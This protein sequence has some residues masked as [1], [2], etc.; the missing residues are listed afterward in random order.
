MGG[1]EA[2]R[3]GMEV[4]RPRGEHPTYQGASLGYN[5]ISVATNGINLHNSDA[6]SLAQAF[7]YKFTGSIFFTIK[8]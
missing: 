7:N 2:G 5:G 6:V 1:G 8:L 3:H 4:I